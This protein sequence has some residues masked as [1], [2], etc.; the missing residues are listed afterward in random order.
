MLLAVT[1]KRSPHVGTTTERGSSQAGKISTSAGLRLFSRLDTGYMSAYQLRWFI[2]QSGLECCAV[3][4]AP[5]GVG[6]RCF[7]LFW[8]RAVL[9]RLL[10]ASFTFFFSICCYPVTCS[11]SPVPTHTYAHTHIHTLLF[12]K[13]WR[14]PGRSARSAP[15][16]SRSPRR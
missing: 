11:P 7:T 5:L 15:S 2:P 14:F 6:L 3:R 16:R 12:L 9:C 1:E 4:L 8:E 13:R 10:L